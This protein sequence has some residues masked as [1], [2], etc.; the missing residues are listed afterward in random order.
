ML[1]T[2]KIY[3]IYFIIITLISLVFIL[4]FKKNINTIYFSIIFL[5]IPSVLKYFILQMEFKDLILKYKNIGNIE[6]GYETFKKSEI[7]EVES[8][9]KRLI[10]II[11]LAYLSFIY[12]I[13]LLFCMLFFL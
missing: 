12:V 13:L 2:N 3:K 4:I 11:K 6:L 5:F 1:S 9:R 10:S 7:E 8:S